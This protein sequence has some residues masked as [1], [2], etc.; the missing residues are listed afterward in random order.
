MDDQIKESGITV[1]ISYTVI[2][3]SKE[4]AQTLA[5][6]LREKGCKVFFD[7]DKLHGGDEW[8]NVIYQNISESDVLCVLLQPG[9]ENSVWVQR[10]VDVARGAHVKILPLQISG[11]ADETAKVRE[12][13][14]ISATQFI[15]NPVNENYEKVLDAIVELSKRTRDDQ[16]EWTKSLERKRTDDI[17]PSNKSFATYSSP[18]RAFPCQIHLATGDYTTLSGIDVFVNSTNDYMQLAHFYEKRT[19]ASSLR[20]AGALKLAGGRIVDSVQEELNRQLAGIGLPLEMREVIATH[21]G[22]PKSRL[23]QENGARYI[24]HVAASQVNVKLFKESRIPITEEDG[25]VDVVK[26]CF[27][28]VREVNR[29][30]GVIS[31]GRSP[32]HAEELANIDTYQPIK[33]IIFPLFGTGSGGLS[34]TEIV[35]P[36]LRGIMEYLTDH[37]SDPHLNLEH[38]YLCA[39]VSSSVKWVKDIMDRTLHLER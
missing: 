23:M 37:K 14:A 13:L 9:T 31:I 32:H 17:A 3:P 34:I 36:M 24:F 29:D 18:Q 12:K 21:A 8:A 11:A 1:F 4:I 26:N 38:V 35:P 2:S 5:D 10:E 30:C 28:K 33:S 27:E 39:Y 7:V 15:S 16:K 6:K 20:L 25:I 22:H 19:L